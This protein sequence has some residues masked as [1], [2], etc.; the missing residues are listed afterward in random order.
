MIVFWVTFDRFISMY[1]KQGNL[2]QIC[3]TI[4]LL[5]DS[6]LLGF[7]ILPL[8][9][10]VYFNLMDLNPKTEM[11]LFYLSLKMIRDFRKVYK[12]ILVNYNL[13]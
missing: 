4:F 1:N 10:T 13:N 7:L 12:S 6:F 3:D 8:Q 5:S 2:V 11:S 9:S